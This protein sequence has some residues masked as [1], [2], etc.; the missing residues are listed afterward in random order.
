EQVQ[1]RHEESVS[2]P[3]RLVHRLVGEQTV[4]DGV[5]AGEEAAAHADPAAGIQ[6]LGKSAEDPQPV[7]PLDPSGAPQQS[8]DPAD[9]APV[10][11]ADE[12][13]RRVQQERRD[14]S[15][16]RG[17]ASAPTTRRMTPRSSTAAAGFAGA[18]P[19]IAAPA[20]GTVARSRCRAA[21]SCGTSTPNGTGAVTPPR[22]A[23]S[24]T[25]RST[26]T[27]TA[28]APVAATAS[29]SAVGSASCAA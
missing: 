2:P 7:R 14:P 29:A 12:A 3:L 25:S 5:V 9:R 11:V 24:S 22:A 10:P 26:W 28:D 15:V 6:A 13:D 4:V 16:L 17:H 19:V 21:T 20:S 8:P 27:N 23:G 18:K 1:Q